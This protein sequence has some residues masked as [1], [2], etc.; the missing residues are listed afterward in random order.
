MAVVIAVTDNVIAVVQ[1]FATFVLIPL[2]DV[3]CPNGSNGPK[4]SASLSMPPM[5]SAR[6]A[7]NNKKEY[8]GFHSV[9]FLL[10]HVT[11]HFTENGN[12]DREFV[13]AE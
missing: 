10:N 12:S 1:L 2:L 5:K 13:S 3:T 9:F 8:F 6:P 4:S 11:P 7:S